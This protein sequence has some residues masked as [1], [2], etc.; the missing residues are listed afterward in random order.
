MGVF[1]SKLNTNM[2]LLESIL[3]GS[4]ELMHKIRPTFTDCGRLFAA[5]GPATKVLNDKLYYALTSHLFFLGRCIDLLKE[6]RNLRSK[7]LLCLQS[8]PATSSNPSILTVVNN[9]A[10]LLDAALCIQRTTRFGFWLMLDEHPNASKEKLANLINSVCDPFVRIIAPSKLRN[11]P[12][13]NIQTTLFLLQN[14]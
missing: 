4:S 10:R 7:I 14:L 8:H 6:G 5:P 13:C 12:K 11:S 2:A 3:P 9:L 1:L